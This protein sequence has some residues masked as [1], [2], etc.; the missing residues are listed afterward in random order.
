MFLLETKKRCGGLGGA[1]VDLSRSRMVRDGARRG[2][3]HRARHRAR[4]RAPRGDG[5]CCV[6]ARGRAARTPVPG[7]GR[8]RCC[9]PSSSIPGRGFGFT[10]RVRA[11]LRHNGI[12]SRRVST[13]VRAADA[14]LVVYSDNTKPTARRARVACRGLMTLYAPNLRTRCSQAVRGARRAHRAARCDRLIVG[15]HL[16]FELRDGFRPRDPAPMIRGFHSDEVAGPLAELAKPSTTATP[17][18]VAAPA[19]SPEPAPV[20]AAAAAVQNDL[21]TFRTLLFPLKGGQPTRAFDARAHA[22]IV[23]TAPIG[24]GVRAAADGVISYSGPALPRHGDAKTAQSIVLEHADGTSSTYT[25]LLSDGLPAGTRVLRGLART[26]RLSSTEP[27]LRV[28]YQRAPR[29]RPTALMVVRSRLERPCRRGSSAGSHRCANG[30][31]RIQCFVLSTRCRAAW[32]ASL[33]RAS[34]QLQWFETTWEGTTASAS[35]NAARLDEVS[36]AA[37]HHGRLQRELVC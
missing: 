11:E 5:R 6:P 3:S 14:G 7:D 32:L 18:P 1:V 26:A 10:R 33:F 30:F 19:L 15:T 27:T 12:D 2:K 37:A 20:P 8:A 25:A 29:R 23:L 21:R 16:H 34:S 36:V 28:A 35:G 9:G 13:T 24:A 17:K 31:W 22:A 4:H